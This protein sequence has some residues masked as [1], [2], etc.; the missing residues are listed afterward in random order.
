MPQYTACHETKFS[1]K[2]IGAMVIKFHFYQPDYNEEKEEE[3]GQF[4]K[5][6]FTNIAHMY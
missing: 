2:Y 1:C 4:V 5:T 6:T 3:R